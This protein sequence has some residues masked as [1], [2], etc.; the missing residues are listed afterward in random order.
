[1]DIPRLGGPA[2]SASLE[3]S[4]DAE[5]GKM[6]SRPSTPLILTLHKVGDSEPMIYVERKSWRLPVD[7]TPRS[8]A[9]DSEDGTGIHQIEFRFWSEWNQL[10]K[11]N[12]M[13]GKLYNWTFEARIPGGGFIWNDGD[14]NFEAPESGYSEM[15]RY[16]YHADLPRE[17]WQ[18]VQHGRYFVKFSDGTH[19]R[20]EFDIDGKSD[21]TP[22]RMASWMSL[23]PGSRNLASPM[24]SS[25]I[26]QG[27]DPDKD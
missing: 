14:F 25:H 10:P 27:E 20:I 12:E 22:L 6:H 11:T 1:M 21:V 26:F 24:K 3:Y 5:T 2:S 7:G 13:Y 4:G 9:L 19:A 8:I 15:I 23:K 18:R 17:K 16:H